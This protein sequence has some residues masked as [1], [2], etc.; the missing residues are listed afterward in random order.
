MHIFIFTILQFALSSSSALIL[1]AKEELSMTS[2]ET[3]AL[4]RESLGVPPK[5]APQPTFPQE[6]HISEF[7]Y[8]S[9]S[10]KRSSVTR[11]DI[12]YEDNSFMTLLAPLVMP[13]P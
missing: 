1:I 10:K 12:T 13:S 5:P 6:G 7:P 8:W 4:V 2:Q 11:L 9:F 3:N